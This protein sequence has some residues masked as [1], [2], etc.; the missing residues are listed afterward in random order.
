[1]SSPVFDY[2]S[3]F[4]HFDMTFGAITIP[5]GLPR[6]KRTSTM[7]HAEY[8]ATSMKNEVQ[9]YR[10]EIFDN[11]GIH[12][13]VHPVPSAFELY[14][15]KGRWIGFSQY[16][17]EAFGQ[18]SKSMHVTVDRK[19]NVRIKYLGAWRAI[20]AYLANLKPHIAWE[21]SVPRDNLVHLRWRQQALWWNA[22]GKI[23]THEAACGGSRDDL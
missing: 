3:G 7:A 4:Q 16:T 21:A 5:F 12:V 22:N 20:S 1:M 9:A 15:V 10:I 14:D 23:S 6:R 11:F 2:L 13:M 18:E 17:L 19:W 8:I